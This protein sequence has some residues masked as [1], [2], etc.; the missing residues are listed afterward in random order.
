MATVATGVK[1]LYENV[2]ERRDVQLLCTFTVRDNECV[3]VHEGGVRPLVATSKH[4]HIVNED[5]SGKYTLQGMSSKYTMHKMS[6]RLNEDDDEQDA[7]FGKIVDV[8]GVHS[9]VHVLDFSHMPIL[10]TYKRAAF[11][12]TSENLRGIDTPVCIV[13][14]KNDE[15]YVCTRKYIYL[16]NQKKWRVS[17]GLE[18]PFTNIERVCVDVLHDKMCVADDGMIKICSLS[19]ATSTEMTVMDVTTSEERGLGISGV[20]YDRAGNIVVSRKK[21][22]Q[23]VVIKRDWTREVMHVE[24]AEGGI[25]DITTTPEGGLL[26]LAKEATEVGESGTS[27]WR[28]ALLRVRD[29]RVEPMYMHTRNV[30][31]MQESMQKRIRLQMLENSLKDLDY[32]MRHGSTRAI[33]VGERERTTVQVCLQKISRV[34]KFFKGFEHFSAETTEVPIDHRISYDTFL[35]FLL[36]CYTGTMHKSSTEG[37]HDAEFLMSRALAAD[38]LHCSLMLEYVQTLLLE[39]MTSQ[40][41]IEM[42]VR[43]E[44]LGIE[45]LITTVRAYIV[46]N[47]R[48][49]ASQCAASNEP[50]VECL[51]QESVAGLFKLACEKIAQG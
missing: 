50:L 17:F 23:V 49:V 47:F 34:A 38:I 35:D 7:T 22:N 41:A 31:R 8:T 13:C 43:A 15:V 45:S 30:G 25:L 21:T 26:V 28:V 3:R 33:I 4:I 40:N 12:S 5:N 29:D 18:G 11:L 44:N 36:F 32:D 51:S 39:S 24:H 27:L 6:A 16:K 48:D 19:D 37:K 10:R 14:G 1:R 42:L 20:K 9:V 46:E 2:L